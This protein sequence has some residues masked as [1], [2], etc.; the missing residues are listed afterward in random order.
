MPH[1]GYKIR[2]GMVFMILDLAILRPMGVKRWHI[3]SKSSC[4]LLDFI[5]K[6]WSWCEDFCNVP[7]NGMRS[8]FLTQLCW[9]SLRNYAMISLPSASWVQCYPLRQRLESWKSTFPTALCRTCTS[10][11]TNPLL[12]QFI[13]T[14][15]SDLSGGLT[16]ETP[17]KQVPRTGFCG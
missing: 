14:P 3:K 1:S 2:L 16:R 8:S 5:L 4:I 6:C 12:G 9:I 13:K 17:G 15:L 11:P 10:H 7:E